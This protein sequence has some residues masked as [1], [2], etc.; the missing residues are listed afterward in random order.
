MQLNCPGC[1]NELQ[2]SGA[3][4]FWCNQCNE[5]KSKSSADYTLIEE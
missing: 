3:V 4:S 5:L 1:S 2:R